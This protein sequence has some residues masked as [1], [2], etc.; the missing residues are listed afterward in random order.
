MLQ[1]K[2]ISLTDAN[3]A[4]L[5]YDLECLEHNLPK[6]Y[7]S[8]KLNKF[9]CEHDTSSEYENVH[10]RLILDKYR[11]DIKN[12]KNLALNRKETNYT[13]TEIYNNSANYLTKILEIHEDFSTI[14]SSFG[15]GTITKIHSLIIQ[16][17][18]I[19]KLKDLIDTIKFQSDGR[20]DYIG[21]GA[22]AVR[23]KKYLLLAKILIDRNI[24]SSSSDK[25]SNNLTSQV[26]KFVENL[27]NHLILFIDESYAFI[28]YIFEN[29]LSE[30]A[31]LEGNTIDVSFIN[32]FTLFYIQRKEYNFL[33]ERYNSQNTEI[34]EL[35]LRILELESENIRLRNE[36]NAITVEKGILLQKIKDE[37][38]LT[39]TL[40]LKNQEL[41]ID[42]EKVKENYIKISLEFESSTK[43]INEQA[44]TIKNSNLTIDSLKAQL[45]EYLKRY[46]VLEE[47]YNRYKIENKNLA[48]ATNELSEMKDIKIKYESLIIN[49]KKELDEEKRKYNDLKISLEARIIDITRINNESVNE[50]GILRAKSSDLENKL[51]EA[52]KIKDKINADFS[53]IVKRLN[54]QIKES[55][56]KLR[57]ITI[58]NDENLTLINQLEQQNNEYKLNYISKVDISKYEEKINELNSIIFDIKA[59]NCS[60]NK[61]L[62]EVEFNYLESEKRL[63]L[64]INERDS[65]NILYRDLLAIYNS[66]K[67]DTGK[68]RSEE[69][70]RIIDISIRLSEITKLY[71]ADQKKIREFDNLMKIERERYQQTIFILEKQVKDL[72]L[73]IEEY[74]K[75][76]D[77]SVSELNEERKKS[78]ILFN[79]NQLLLEK[80][81]NLLISIENLKISNTEIIHLNSQIDELRIQLHSQIKHNEILTT[82]LE[83]VERELQNERTKTLSTPRNAN[84]NDL[85]N[86]LDL[87]FSQKEKLEKELIEKKT[88]LSQLQIINETMNSKLE[89]LGSEMSSYKDQNKSFNNMHI[90]IKNYLSQ[91]E[92]VNKVKLHL[93][94]ENSDLKNKLSRCNIELDQL[95]HENEQCNILLE[96]LKQEIN[97]LRK[98]DKRHEILA[99]SKME[100]DELKNKLDK[101]D[102]QKI[103]SSGRKSMTSSN[104]TNTI[105]VKSINNTQDYLTIKE[106]K[107]RQSLQTSNS[108]TNSNSKRNT[109]KELTSTAAKAKEDDNKG[110]NFN[111]SNYTNIDFV[112]NIPQNLLLNLKHWP[113]LKDWF[114]ALKIGT[115]G[116]VSLNLLMKASKDG[117]GSDVFR[118]K[119]HGKAS[120]LII[121]LTSF[122]KLIGGFT[123][124]RWNEH[125]EFRYFRDDSKKSFLFS[126]TNG[127]KYN[128]KRTEFAICNGKD[129]G[130]IFG[131]GSD[132]EIVDNCDVN[133]NNYSAIGH[134]YDYKENPEHFYGGNKFTIK[135]Y[136]VYEVK[137]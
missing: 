60:L 101:L 37:K 12:I 108:L 7:F 38:N 105:T 46:K 9:F 51:D 122:D 77:S 123:P 11:E 117:F 20:A 92:E 65:V 54:M 81:K 114:A 56:K 136:E 4:V 86:Q 29:L 78:N 125:L 93:E 121:V 30:I 97:E 110:F 127:K 50:I 43:K 99:N 109:S 137:Y 27:Q 25:N 88:K 33:A 90:Q 13:L 98:Y 130:P 120:T 41:L 1:R 119:C 66:I 132:L 74:H 10:F 26:I 96:K 31:K 8:Y 14:I 45:E 19:F 62:E 85:K 111:M 103:V 113:L 53:E 52:I 91:I 69:D 131:G 133:Y 75:K 48:M 55:E 49:L 28:K 40:M 36:N 18:E 116:K 44:S 24:S 82:R 84:I 95:K 42:L 67:D 129:I 128:L 76:K 5:N 83:Q 79:E 72:N 80:N 15:N 104:V 63:R 100:I 57:E 94:M 89:I 3:S 134:T 70:R 124:L 64:T 16:D 59:L 23:E 106:L 71:E 34:T 2:F 102:N 107:E 32:N 21:I 47:E 115:P 112:K 118:N 58:K 126:F 39:D 6:K 135:D 73:I 22:D 68:K 87:V 17:H 35:K 61:R